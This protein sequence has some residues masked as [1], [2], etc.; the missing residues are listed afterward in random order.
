MI[1]RRE[2]EDKLTKELL[3]IVHFNSLKFFFRKTSRLYIYVKWNQLD[4]RSYFQ[5]HRRS[6]ILSQTTQRSPVRIKDRTGRKEV[7][8]A[9]ALHF[10]KSRQVTEEQRLTLARF[11]SARFSRHNWR[12]SLQARRATKMEPT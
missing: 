9:Q 11:L 12:I 6:R 8:C 4:N 1:H 3:K 5:W 2:F 10:G 7:A